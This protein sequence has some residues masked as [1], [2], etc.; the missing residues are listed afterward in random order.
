[1]LNSALTAHGQIYTMT[2]R[3]VFGI[4]ILAFSASNGQPGDQSSQY[5]GHSQ[6]LQTPSLQH[7]TDLNQSSQ[8]TGLS[9]HLQTPLQPSFQ[10]PTDLNNPRCITF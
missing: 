8:Y 7:P 3:Y 10:H 5:P 9:Q 2:N 6:H 1:M 4:M